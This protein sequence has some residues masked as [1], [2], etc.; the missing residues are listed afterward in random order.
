MIKVEF[1]LGATD[2]ALAAIALPHGQL[3]GGGNDSPS[4]RICG[5][6]R[7]EIFV[8]LDRDESELED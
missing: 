8:A 2:H 5:R 4:R 6:W 1:I 3:Y 7:V